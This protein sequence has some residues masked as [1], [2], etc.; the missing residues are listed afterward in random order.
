MTLTGTGFTGATGVSFNGVAGT[1]LNVV[2]DTS[3]TVVTPATFTSGPVTITGPGGTSLATVNYTVFAPPVIATQPAPTTVNQNSSAT[4]TVVATGATP[5]SYQWKRGT[6]NVGTNSSTLTITSAQAADVGTYSVVVTN[7]DG[8]TTSVNATLSVVLIPVINVQ[9]A[10]LTVPNGD[11]ASFSVTTS[12]GTAPLTYQWRRNGV[13]IT[14]GGAAATF[15]LAPATLADT[16]AVFSVIVS[17]AAGSVTS[18]DATLTV[19]PTRHSAD[20]N[21]DLKIS[22]AELTRVIELYN[23][24]VASVRTGEY[25]TQAGTE[26]LFAPGP[27]PI[28]AG[29]HSAD[30]SNRTDGTSMNGRI[31]LFELTRVIELYNY[32]DSA[33]VRTGE[34]RPQVG[35]EDGFAPGP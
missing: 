21:A 27:G 5:L 6:T 1:A 19:L 15:T 3:A 33:G 29:F 9:P 23:A 34:Y 25:R 32:R 16:G 14:T 11:A 26:D 7:A 18:S 28:T 2:S 30:K 10:N 17:N 22:L 13:N 4:F 8:S 12:A 20:T 35:T 24:T 31:D